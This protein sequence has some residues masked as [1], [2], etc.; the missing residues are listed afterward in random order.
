M[1]IY[2]WHIVFCFK[3]IIAYGMVWEPF[4][5]AYSG[6]I[7]TLYHLYNKF[8]IFHSESWNN[9]ILCFST[10][11][12]RFAILSSKPHF[13]CSIL[14]SSEHYGC[15][16]VGLPTEW[17]RCSCCQLY[18]HSG[19]SWSSSS[20]HHQ[21]PGKHHLH[22]GLQWGVHCEHC[23]HQLCRNWRNSFTEYL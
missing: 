3:C 23:S 5:L 22:S 13:H 8:T 1:C 19:G 11:A 12:F 20:L 4:L 9:V 6:F 2:R 21:C 16:S 14:W 15:S 10:C 17:R 7:H 18:C